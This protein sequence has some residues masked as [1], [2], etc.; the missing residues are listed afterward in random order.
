MIT[1][2]TVVELREF[3]SEE[4]PETIILDDLDMALIGVAETHNGIIAVY[5]RDKVIEHFAEEM[6]S[7][8]EAE[9]WYYYNTV[10]A[11]AYAGELA[12]IFLA[13]LNYV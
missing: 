1:F 3:L 8:E 4:S 10:R 11:C 12:P 7:M 2:N 13:G 9:E 5:D 6:E